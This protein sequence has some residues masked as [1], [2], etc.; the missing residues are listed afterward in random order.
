MIPEVVLGVALLLFFALAATAQELCPAIDRAC[1][2]DPA[3]CAADRAGPAGGHKKEYEEA[4][5]TLGANGL[6]TFKEVTFP[7]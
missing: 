7:Y 4:A 1:G 3:L 2:L 5:K 6:Q